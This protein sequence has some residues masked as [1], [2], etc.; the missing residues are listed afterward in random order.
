MEKHMAIL[1]DLI[2]FLASD[3]LISIRKH[4][5]SLKN[6][7]AHFFTLSCAKNLL[8]LKTH[9]TKDDKNKLYAVCV[10]IISSE[11]KSL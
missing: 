4:F 9:L 1:I 10:D 2:E 3:S 6:T 7:L 8:E 5:K 11:N